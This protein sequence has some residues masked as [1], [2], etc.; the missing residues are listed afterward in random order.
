[1][2]NFVAIA[3][4]TRQAAM[5]GRRAMLRLAPGKLD[6]VGDAVVAS[7]D[8]F[9]SIDIDQLVNLWAMTS[10][11]EMLR[12]VL[13]GLLFLY[14]LLAVLPG[15][16]PNLIAAA[17]TDFGLGEDALLRIRQMLSPGHAV[18][19]LLISPTLVPALEKLHAPA[20]DMHRVDGS[21]LDRVVSAF[22]Q[23]QL[24]A[25]GQHRAVYSQIPPD[26]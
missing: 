14:P 24:V 4:P 11:G 21:K 17:L 5:E 13:L 25:A 19:F 12:T 18:V 23:G 1:M 7:V 26:D 6:E 16:A 3:Y 2:P 10:K 22:E 20:I 8:D 15:D 9:G